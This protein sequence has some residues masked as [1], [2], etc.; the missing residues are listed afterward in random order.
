MRLPGSGWVVAVGCARLGG[1][2]GAAAVTQDDL[3]LLRCG[4][5][6][7]GWALTPLQRGCISSRRWVLIVVLVMCMSRRLRWI[8][9]VISMVRM[10]GAARLL[11]ARHAVLRSGMCRWLR[12]VVAVVPEVVEPEWVVED[13]SGA[14]GPEQVEA[15]A[16]AVAAV[17][18]E[19]PFD[20]SVPGLVRFAVVRTGG[21]GTG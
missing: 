5:R 17:Q 2:V 9:P 18:W 15:A 11:M 14:G 8:L 3:I 6:V 19:R 7:R 21:V 1:R 4:S 12:V 20:L 10:R 16:A 13:V